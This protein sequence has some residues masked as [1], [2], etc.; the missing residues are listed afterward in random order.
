LP[1]CGGDGGGVR[2]AAISFGY[3]VIFSGEEL[4]EPFGVDFA[5]EEIWVSKDAPEKAGVGLDS[6]DGIFVE[7]AAQA[8]DGFFAGVAPGD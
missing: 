8:R 5:A 6:G 3:G 4:V 7:G 1:Q 2:G